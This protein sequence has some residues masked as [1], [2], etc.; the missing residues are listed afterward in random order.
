MYFLDY[1]SLY[2]VIILFNFSFLLYTFQKHSDLKTLKPIN[3]KTQKKIRAT[4]YIFDSFFQTHLKKGNGFLYMKTEW[5]LSVF[6]NTMYL[7]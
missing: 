1:H 7:R 2:K 5:R 4:R 6:A 3:L